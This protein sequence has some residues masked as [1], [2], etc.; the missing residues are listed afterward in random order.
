M[1]DT[2][3][4]SS[5]AGAAL[6]YMVRASLGLGPLHDDQ[7]VEASSIG[8]L[9]HQIDGLSLLLP[10]LLRSLEESGSLYHDSACGIRD[11][12]DSLTKAAG[13]WLMTTPSSSLSTLFTGAEASQGSTDTSGSKLLSLA[14][15]LPLVVGLDDIHHV[16]NRI[17]NLISGSKG[18]KKT[19][20][21]NHLWS[22]LLSWDDYERKTGLA[23][24]FQSLLGPLRSRL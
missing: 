18:D 15:S 24:W 3:A 16:T 9:P 7:A 4:S 23:H 12:I 6:G 22:I 20:V 17:E 14:L 1:L 5:L 19:A 10:L 11:V 13:S 2:S 21:L 8:W